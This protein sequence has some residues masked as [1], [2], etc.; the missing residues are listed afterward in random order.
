MR[1]FQSLERIW[2]AC[3]AT[4]PGRPSRWRRLREIDAEH[5]V[6]ESVKPGASGNVSMM[7]TPLELIERLAAP[8]SL[9]P[10]RLFNHRKQPFVCP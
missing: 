1:S 10:R 7:L 5:L 3:C 6:Y 9:P 2:N 8:T 4:A